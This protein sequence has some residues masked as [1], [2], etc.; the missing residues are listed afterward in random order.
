LIKPPRTDPQQRLEAVRTLTHGRGADLV[1]EAA[2]ACGAARE[3]LD[4]ARPGGS[5]VLTGYAQPVGTEEIDFYSQVVKKHLKIQGIWV[6]DTRHTRQA[7][8]LVLEQPE[9]FS[10]LI[11]HRFPLEE[12]N[13]ALVVMQTKEALKAVLTFK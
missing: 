4:L 11:T 12:A 13:N 10:K 3:A 7:M 1:L 9:R 8:E 2:G 6:S 5:C